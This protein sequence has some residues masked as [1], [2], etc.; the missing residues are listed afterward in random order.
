[1]K[2]TYYVVFD[3]NGIQRFCKTAGFQLKAGE[4]AQ[5]VELD[6]DN[7]LFDPVR[8]PKVT[9]RVNAAGVAKVVDAEVNHGEEV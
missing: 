4:F 7:A 1:V 5:F 9:L 2:D 8:V 3:K 6:V